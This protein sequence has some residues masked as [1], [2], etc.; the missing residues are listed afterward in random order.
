MT[1]RVQEN[2][3]AVVLFAIFVAAII[4]STNYGP[5]ARLVPIP[6]A[7][8]GAILTIVQLIFQN[9]R[10]NTQLQVDF[11]E[12]L[13]SKVEA[14]DGGAAPERADIKKRIGSVFEGAAFGLKDLAAMGIVALLVA[15]M[16]VFGPYAA[17]FAFAA[18][19]FIAARQYP[20]LKALTYAL[21]FSILLY[22][23]FAIVLQVEFDLSPVGVGLF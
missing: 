11:L 5:R 15:L 19:Y 20:I 1:R 22:L 12:M 13:T 23:M 21:G 7:A 2:I 3:I 18:G 8:L 6:I 9:F 10:T 16:L 14:R 17:A 4:A